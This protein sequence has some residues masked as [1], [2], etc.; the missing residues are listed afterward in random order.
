MG[1][2][3]LKEALKLLNHPEERKECELSFERLIESHREYEVD[4]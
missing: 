1:A 3:A 2:D 4:F